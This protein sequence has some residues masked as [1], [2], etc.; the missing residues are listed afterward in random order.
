MIDGLLVE[1]FYLNFLV[2]VLWTGLL[3]ALLLHRG[4][5]FAVAVSTD[6]VLLQKLLL[7][8]LH[9]LGVL[10]QVRF[11]WHQQV[12]VECLQLELGWNLVQLG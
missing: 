9:H 12:N 4:G 10:F 3:F 8:E 2:R 7:L 1:S 6:F 11:Q 5:R